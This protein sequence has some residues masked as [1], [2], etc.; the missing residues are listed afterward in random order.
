MLLSFEVAT[1][2]QGAAI[3]TLSPSASAAAISVVPKRFLRQIRTREAWLF[4]KKSPDPARI[5]SLSLPEEDASLQPWLGPLTGVL[6]PRQSHAQTGW[7]AISPTAS[8]LIIA[9]GS[10]ARVCSAAHLQPERGVERASIAL[11]ISVD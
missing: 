4:G 9:L 5:S 1:R 11:A 2:P 7:L 10:Y 6:Q 8:G 3:S